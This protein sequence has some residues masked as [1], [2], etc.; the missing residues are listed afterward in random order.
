MH[1]YIL[2]A[3]ITFHKFASSFEVESMDIGELY[4]HTNFRLISGY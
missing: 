3:V 1:S 2:M 4:K